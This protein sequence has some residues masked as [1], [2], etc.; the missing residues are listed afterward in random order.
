MS[1][2]KLKLNDGTQI[3]IEFE[4]GVIDCGANVGEITNIFQQAGA[5]VLAFEPNKYAFEIL[6]KR[7]HNNLRVKCF[8]KGV[9]GYKQGKRKLF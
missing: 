9:I 2:C 3:E 8:Q 7:F 4:I 5:I 1:K 6:K